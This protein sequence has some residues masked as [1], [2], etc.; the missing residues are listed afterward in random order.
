MNK[1]LFLILI[2]IPGIIFLVPK[3]IQTYADLIIRPEYQNLSYEKFMLT[4]LLQA[5]LLV[6]GSIFLGSWSTKKIGWHDPIL[7]GIENNNTQQVKQGVATV[8]VPSLWYTI[9]AA[10]VFT[11]VIYMLLF[12][13]LDADLITQLNDFSFPALMTR[14]FYGG[15]V[16]EIILRWGV[17]S[18][19]VFIGLKMSS[20]Q[21]TVWW[22]AIT[23]AAFI[24]G[25]G[26]LPY[27]LAISK[28]P[29]LLQML[30]IIKANVFA[31]MF[32]GWI[33][34]RFGLIAAMV[35]HIFFHLSWFAVA[36]ISSFI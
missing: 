33:F 1:K 24:F 12:P 7:D 30:L 15:V 17:L 4:A 16:E 3:L 36:V 18:F 28:D 11:A 34:K 13:L 26:H 20:Q 8:V 5:I 27:Y 29:T 21:E 9:P 22:A 10:L 23:V 6:V 35:A 25:G 31:G 32:F 19:F 14:I 2:S